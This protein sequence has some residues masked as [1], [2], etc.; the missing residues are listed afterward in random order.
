MR[1]HVRAALVLVAACSSPK[2]DPPPPAPELRPTVT[3]DG[4]SI[5]EDVATHLAPD[6]AA[7]LTRT[8]ESSGTRARLK[9]AG[10]DAS[11]ASPTRGDLGAAAAFAVS[12]AASP[13]LSADV[14]FYTSAA[15]LDAAAA[16]VGPAP[17][18]RN[19]AYL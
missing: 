8:W 1:R 18:A 3:A 6:V 15:A 2:G 10:L 5:P 16:R 19:G 9:S 4:P 14:H 7:E 12:R 17:H 13:P 11:S